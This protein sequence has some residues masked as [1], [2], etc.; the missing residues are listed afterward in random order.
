MLINPEQLRAA[1]ATNPH[2]DE[3]EREKL[4]ELAIK[5]EVKENGKRN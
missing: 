1:A 4:A 5:V 3:W 2:L